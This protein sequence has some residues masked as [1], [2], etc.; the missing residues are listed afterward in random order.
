VE[1]EWRRTLENGGAVAVVDV[2]PSDA[3]ADG[4]ETG[5]RERRCPEI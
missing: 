4:G 5:A 2:G 1:A 3:G